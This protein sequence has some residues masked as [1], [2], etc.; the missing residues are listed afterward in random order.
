MRSYRLGKQREDGS[1]STLY[2][3]FAFRAGQER[4]DETLAHQCKSLPLA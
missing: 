4:M 2:Q 1:V 3:Y